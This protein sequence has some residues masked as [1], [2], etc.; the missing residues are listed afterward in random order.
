MVNAL[1][2]AYG[3]ASDDAGTLWRKPA[4]SMS[5]SLDSIMTSA[6]QRR[7]AFTAEQQTIKAEV[8]DESGN[9]QQVDETGQVIDD[10]DEEEIVRER[11]EQLAK[12]SN[13]IRKVQEKLKVMDQEIVIQEGKF[14]SL[15]A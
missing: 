8:V 5:E 11:E 12:M 14:K 4:D 9:V 2:S 10:R 6:F 7:A 15:S 3:E 13:K 1:S